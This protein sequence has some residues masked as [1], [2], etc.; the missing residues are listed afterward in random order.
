MKS[1]KSSKANKR[2]TRPAR[3]LVSR[4]SVQISKFETEIIK[5]IFE[6]FGGISILAIDCSRFRKIETEYGAEAYC[7]IKKVFEGVLEEVAG[8]SGA[9][10]REDYIYDYA[11]HGLQYIVIL[12][13]SRDELALTRP[14]ILEKIADRVNR[15]L[16]DAMWAELKKTKP[17]RRLTE[18]IQKIPII[19]VGHHSALYNPCFDIHDVLVTT[20]EQAFKNAKVQ[21]ER[22]K[23]FQKELVHTLVHHSDL[24]YPVFQGIFN[25]QGMELTTLGQKGS[26]ISIESLTEHI[27]G[28]ESLIRIR[29]ERLDEFVGQ[30]NQFFSGQYLRPD[31]L[32]EMAKSCHVALELDQTCI[33]HA[34]REG[35]D[36]PGKLL[37]NVLPRNLYY[38]D[39]LQQFFSEYEE[40]VFELSETE[41]ISNEELMTQARKKLKAKNFGIAADD[42]GK[43]YAGIERVMQ[44]QPDIIKLDRGIISDIHISKV[45]QNYVKGLMA[46]AEVIGSKILAEGVEKQQEALFLQSIGVDLIQGFWLHRPECCEDIL[47]K[48]EGLQD[49]KHSLDTAS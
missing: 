33:K 4:S 47:D 8:K 48:L 12:N 14:G 16:I 13:K 36:L 26:E 28:F 42:F 11:F 41:Q 37:V 32:F 30:E 15:A 25:L 20:C 21:V 19:A 17:H 44:I 10:R 49:E 2:R 43:S 45:K 6:A 9:L 34:A 1:L 5:P 29:S 38:F 24:L 31:I 40:V 35:V 3:S 18:C 27:Y 22:L 46:S 7:N 23:N 39:Y